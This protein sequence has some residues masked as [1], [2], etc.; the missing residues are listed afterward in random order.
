MT[1]W[2]EEA[3]VKPPHSAEA[4]RSAMIFD[5]EVRLPN[6]LL[7]RT[8]RA[9]MAFSLEAR[10]PYLDRRVVELANGLSPADCVRLLPPTSKRLLKRIAAK[11]VPRGVVYRRKRGFNL[12]VEQWLTL[13]FGARID[14]FLREQTID[15]LN[16]DYL[17]SVYAEHTRGHHRAALLWAW[18]VLEQW[19]R[20]W[21]EGEAVPNIPA[22]VSDRDAYELLLR[23]SESLSRRGSQAHA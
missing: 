9:T 22:V 14:R 1:A 19:Y 7:P 8:D 12:P 20:L 2:E 5:Q 16:Y 4:V 17:R 13:D 10:V 18:V 21:I 15:A 3:F 6:D 11:H 23:A